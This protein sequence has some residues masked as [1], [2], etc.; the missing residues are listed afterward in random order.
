MKQ[1][2]DY[3]II[4]SS[5]GVSYFFREKDEAHFESTP[6]IN[7]INVIKMLDDVPVAKRGPMSKNRMCLDSF[8]RYLKAATNRRKRNIKKE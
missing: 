6:T 3:Y 4:R 2:V 7:E 1:D 5:D 8:K